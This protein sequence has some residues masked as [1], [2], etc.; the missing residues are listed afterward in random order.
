MLDAITTGIGL[1]PF[2]DRLEGL[3]SC[4]QFRAAL[5]GPKII[6]GTLRNGQDSQQAE[7]GEQQQI[8]CSLQGLLSTAQEV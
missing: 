3:F 8:L 1:A 7:E 5:H 4:E 2:F 6:K